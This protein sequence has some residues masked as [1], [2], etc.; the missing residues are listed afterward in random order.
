MTNSNMEI[1]DNHNHNVLVNDEK[2]TLKQFQSIYNILK[3]TS[4]RLNYRCNK[5]IQVNLDNLRTLNHKFIQFIE[6]HGNCKVNTSK[7]I[8]SYVDNNSISHDSFHQFEAIPSPHHAA[9]E[10]ISIKYSFALLINNQIEH[11]DMDIYIRSLVSQNE[12]L[13]LNSSEIEKVIFLMS[14]QVTAIVKIK[15]VDYLIAESLMNVIKSWLESLPED[16]RK[17]YDLKKYSHFAPALLPVLLMIIA[18]IVCYQQIDSLFPSG[19]TE[20]LIAKNYLI[21][22]IVLISLFK[23][24]F[25]LAKVIENKIDG[26]CRHSY[27]KLN[28]FDDKLIQKSEKSNIKNKIIAF[29]SFILSLIFTIFSSYIYDLVKIYIF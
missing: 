5:A 12:K 20:N 11:Y 24:S 23:L 28:E 3:G 2:M 1:F 18:M 6:T 29:S 19:I 16:N 15:Y 9:V 10:E 7:V 22:I 25:F 26:I 27:I 21:I 14:N 13:S 17:L 8:V 4:N